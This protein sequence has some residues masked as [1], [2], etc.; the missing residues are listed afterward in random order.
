M[1]DPLGKE[2][3]K[4]ALIPTDAVRKQGLASA[5]PRLKRTS[6]QATNL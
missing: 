5:K 6:L 4:P 1:A 2:Q 3:E